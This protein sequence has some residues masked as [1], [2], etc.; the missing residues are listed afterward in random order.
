MKKEQIGL[1]VPEHINK[2]LQ[3]KADETGLSKNDTILMLI[4][5]G[6]T[7]CDNGFQKERKS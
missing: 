6:F 1:R 5:I 7:V 4:N 2:R 3:E